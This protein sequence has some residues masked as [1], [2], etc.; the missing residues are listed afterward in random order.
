MR[1]TFVALAVALLVL[2]FIS[3]TQMGSD[4]FFKIKGSAASS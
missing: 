3:R 1:E 2:Y 4:L